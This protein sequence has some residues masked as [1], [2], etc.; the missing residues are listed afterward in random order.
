[1]KVVE[2][3]DS[4]QG[5][6]RYAGTWMHF[7]RVAGCNL[8]C[9]WCDT[10]QKNGPS[11]E[12]SPRDIM[13]GLKSVWGHVC[14]TGGEP[15]LYIDELP[16]LREVAPHHPIHIETNG[17]LLTP[18]FWRDHYCGFRWAFSPKSV[19]AANQ[20]V[21]VFKGEAYRAAIANMHLKLVYTG[22]DLTPYREVRRYFE[23]QYLQPL[24][25]EGKMSN[26]PETLHA[27]EL[28]PQWRLSVQLHKLLGLR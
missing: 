2:L 10:P 3:F 5:E 7:V 20:L 19:D 4:I 13:D 14:M 26:L 18:E 8:N 25:L 21:S 27:I 24:W 12:M 11:I 15:L 1:M 23:Y 22:Q 6:G 16:K 9:S 28:D 17:T